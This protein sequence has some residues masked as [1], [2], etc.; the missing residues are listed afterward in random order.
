[1]ATTLER[2]YASLN[3][4]AEHFGLHPQ[5]VRRMISDGDLHAVR[6]GGQ[7][8]ISLAEIERAAAARPIGNPGSK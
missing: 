2:K 4:T 5:T 3:E 1:M 8:R 6:I 7:I